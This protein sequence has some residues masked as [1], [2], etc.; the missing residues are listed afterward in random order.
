MQL[1]P[2]YLEKIQAAEQKGKLEGEQQKQQ[3]IAVKMM[4][5][6]IPLETISELTE[7]SIEQL[8]SLR[9]QLENS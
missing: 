8:Q 2:L 6:N 7:L 9:S 1:S 3:E 4:Q 5:K